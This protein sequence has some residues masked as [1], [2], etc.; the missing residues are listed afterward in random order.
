VAY[1]HEVEP[2]IGALSKFE[3]RIIVSKVN[4]E[5]ANVKIVND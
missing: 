4:N 3:D 1:E 5:K 2:I